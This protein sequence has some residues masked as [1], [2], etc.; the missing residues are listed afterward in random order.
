M[1]ES[2]GSAGVARRSG[3]P[4]DSAVETVVFSE[5]MKIDGSRLGWDWKGPIA[6]RWRA[7]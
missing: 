6:R 4:F 5:A 3:P 7:R 2:T 1:V